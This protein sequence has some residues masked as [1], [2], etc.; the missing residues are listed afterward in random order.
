MSRH[1]QSRGLHQMSKHARRWN[2]APGLHELGRAAPDH[3]FE[4]PDEWDEARL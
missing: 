2:L 4:L 3:D 1:R